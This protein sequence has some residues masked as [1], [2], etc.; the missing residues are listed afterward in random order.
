MAVT[1]CLLLAVL[2]WSRRDFATRLCAGLLLSIAVQNLLI[3]AMRSSPDVQFAL[4]WQRRMIVTV[5][6]SFVFYY[7]FTLA[8]TNTW[9]QRRFLTTMYLLLLV[10]VVLIP[11]DVFIKE[12]Q[13]T[14]YGYRPVLGSGIYVLVPFSISLLTGGAINLIRY[15]RLLLSREEKVRIVLLLVAAPLPLIGA[16]L[17]GFVK[18]P[19]TAVWCNLSSSVL[20]SVALLKYSLLDRRMLVRRGLS[21]ILVSTVVAIP[22]VAILL[23]SHELMIPEVEPWWIHAIY[24]IILAFLLRPLYGWAQNAVD[25]LFYRERHDYVKALEQFSRET[26][27]ISEPAQLSFTLLRLAS[28]AV[29]CSTA[30]LLLPSQDNNDFVL[31]SQIGMDNPPSGVILSNDSP[32]VKWLGK[33]GQ[34]LSL[35][36][37]Q[38]MP[39]FHTLPDN[40]R[41]NLQ[42]M[43]TAL[44]VPARSSQ[45][46]LLG[47]LLLGEKLN[48]QS[49]G[50]GDLQILSALGGPITITLENLKLYRDSIQVS[51]NFE[52]WLSSMS[53]CILI[54]NPDLSIRFA[55]TAAINTLGA[56]IGQI[57][58]QLMGR[59]TQ[60][61]DCPFLH[62]LT[63]DDRLWRRTM[64]IRAQTFDSASTILEESDANLSLIKVLR[65]I[66]EQK[67]AEKELAQSR[68]KLRNLYTRARLSREEERTSIAREFHDELGQTLSTVHMNLDWLNKRLP[69][70]SGTIADK[71]AEM[72]TLTNQAIQTVR[73]VAS[74]LRPAILDNLGILA[75]IEWQFQEFGTKNDIKCNL[76]ISHRDIDISPRYS[77]EVFRIFQETLTNISRHA[78]ATRVTV[79]FKR[80][81]G[82]LILQVQDNGRGITEE[83]M[84]SPFSVGLIGM[85]ERAY[86]IGGL[87]DV[88]SAPGGGT[89]VNLT[90]PL[91]ATTS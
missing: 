22:Y 62:Y 79:S 34:P 48:R 80:E 42:A 72:L 86:S 40:E 54:V 1:L 69:E 12:M 43:L 55:N 11:T 18:L 31:V 51:R 47:I 56:R 50:S 78:G 27:S 26:Q 13:V 76:D 9:G 85:R 63:G 24:L 81:E 45:G 84:E 39:E 30:G 70:R 58:F 14:D 3:F 8:Y 20:F 29:G 38:N 17:G 74:R 89:I 82:N 2:L 68:E 75:A 32:I 60:C 23:M 35:R 67:K 37:L 83:Q 52:A 77:T 15:Y 66:T 91:P 44:L 61:P 28:G 90:V 73:D 65:D 87:L 53:D 59:E 25:R 6:G 21:Y 33:N 57:C 64:N 19:P 71:I 49:Y 5:M 46:T 7:H 4:V 41:Q 10:L 16:I 36:D 88:M